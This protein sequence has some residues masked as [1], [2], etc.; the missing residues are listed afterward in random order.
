M[1]DIQTQRNRQTG[2]ITREPSLY[3]V[4]I[5]NDDHTTM[6]FVVHIL[7]TI[8]CKSH[9]DAEALMMQVHNEG[10][11]VAG[12]YFKDIAETK[13][14]KARREARENGFP[15][16]LTVERQITDLPF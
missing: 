10:H 14:A 11:G 13:A 15:L 3:D 9:D 8:F 5:H 1:A 6:D 12:T 16:R 7:T 4:I 2:F